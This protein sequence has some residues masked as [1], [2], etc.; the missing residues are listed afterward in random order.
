M[1]FMNA[2]NFALVGMTTL[3]SPV[4]AANADVDSIFAAIDLTSISAA[5]AGVGV[6]I[7]GIT[8]VM[9]SISLGKRTV[10]KA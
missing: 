1:K 10:N 6:V 9:K 2:K 3:A 5:V 8:M 4:F 7:I